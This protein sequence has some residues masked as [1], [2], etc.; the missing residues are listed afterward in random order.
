MSDD[1]LR[2]A[3]TKLVRAYIDAINAWDFDAMRGMLAEDF[4]FEQMFAPPGMDSRFEGR[5]SLLEFQKSFVDTIKT[6]NLHDVQ[7]ET[8]YSDPGEIVATYRSDMEFS[9]PGME[10]RNKYIC[11]FTVREG[12]IT[13]FKEY[14][15]PVPLILTFG[16]TVE[17]PFGSPAD[18][19]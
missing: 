18:T 7:L 12:C 8:L 10:Y 15:D 6:E 2:D 1:D 9:D 3:N 5:E 11:R 14:Y 19:T 17:S 4:V 16:G 13:A